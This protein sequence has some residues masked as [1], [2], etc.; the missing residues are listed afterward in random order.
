MDIQA[1]AVKQNNDLTSS[2]CSLIARIQHFY[3]PSVYTPKQNMVYY[4]LI[5]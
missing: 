2:D 5:I 1:M 4:L 3:L